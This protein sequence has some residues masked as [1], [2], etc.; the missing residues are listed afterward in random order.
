MADISVDLEML[1]QTATQLN[2]LINEFDNASNIVSNAGIGDATID[3]A[4]DSFAN[5]WK[6]HR[7]KLVSSMR[8]VQQMASQGYQGYT[9]TD[10]KL[11]QDLRKDSQA[12]S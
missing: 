6:V 4:L 11:A 3:G 9:S 12:S 7:E 8:A 10:D 5:D 1:R 2:N